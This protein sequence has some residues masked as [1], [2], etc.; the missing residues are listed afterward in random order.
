MAT[1][2]G[3]QEIFKRIPHTE[4]EDTYNN[5]NIGRKKLH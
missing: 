1:R 4:K 2:P 3:L 5:E